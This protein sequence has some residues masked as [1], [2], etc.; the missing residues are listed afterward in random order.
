MFLASLEVNP[1]LCNAT[2]SQLIKNF[3]YIYIYLIP[4]VDSNRMYWLL[5]HCN[6]PVLGHDKA[7][8]FFWN[9]IG[10]CIF[11]QVGRMRSSTT[12]SFTV[13]T[14]TACWGRRQS[15]SPSWSLRMTLATLIVSDSMS[16]VIVLHGPC[17]QS[18]AE[19]Q[20]P[21]PF[22]YVLREDQMFSAW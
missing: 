6:M 5:L 4:K 12:S 13:W 11:K 8:G 15:S 19:S 21:C 9:L 20:C 2:K 22:F 18:R 17:T 7:V 1:L 14:G 3:F 16:E 10:L